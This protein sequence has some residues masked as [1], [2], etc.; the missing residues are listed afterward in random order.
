[1]PHATL[2]TSALLVALAA[3]AGCDA[4][5]TSIRRLPLEPTASPGRIA[6]SPPSLSLGFLGAQGELGVRITTLDGDSV[7]GLNVDWTSTNPG[8][9]TVNSAGLVTA[10]QEGATSI[11]ARVLNLADTAQVVVERVPATVTLTA[12]SALFTEIGETFGFGAS[13][14]DGGGVTLSGAPVVWSVADTAVASVSSTGTV[15]AKRQGLTTVRARSGSAGSSAQLRVSTGPAELRV[16]PTTVAFTS[17]GDSLR[18]TGTVRDARGDLLDFPIVY[19]WQDTSVAH[20]TSSGLIT[21]RGIGTTQLT[22]QADSLLRS[23]QVTVTQVAD[24]VV[25]GSAASTTLLPGA[26][27]SYSAAAFD[28]NGNAIPAAAFIWTS[29]NGTVA[30]VNGNGVVTAKAGGTAFIR[31][32][33]GTVSDS[34][35]V[36]VTGLAVDSIDAKPDSVSVT[37]GATSQITVRYFVQGGEVSGG[38]ATFTSDSTAIASVNGSGLITG[39]KAGATW[40]RAAVDTTAADSVRVTV[41]A[42]TPSPGSPGGR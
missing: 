21:A 18:L 9:A 24:S 37:T 28:A 39:V 26:T 23:I 11:V 19:A 15:T 13:V 36:T 42:P 25:I 22:A 1:M 27:R 35:Q 29:G 33:S 34:V 2:R 16:E 40:I 38:S 12:D 20:V 5:D 14:S 41:T 31:A 7:T 17:L 6:L 10:V 30:T 8:V 4:N 3:L 32:R